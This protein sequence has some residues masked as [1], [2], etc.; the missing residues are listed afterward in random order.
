MKKNDYFIFMSRTLKP[1]SFRGPRGVRPCRSMSMLS[2]SSLPERSVFIRLQRRSL[3]KA[4]VH[5]CLNSLFWIPIPP[6]SN[7]KSTPGYRKSTVD[8]GLEPLI[9]GKNGL[10]T[11]SLPACRHSFCPIKTREWNR[12]NQKPTETGQKIN[13]LPFLIYRLLHAR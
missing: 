9:W 5:P 13:P 10:Q 4:D 7:P 8:L 1:M 2:T 12:A 11:L 3:A 6:N